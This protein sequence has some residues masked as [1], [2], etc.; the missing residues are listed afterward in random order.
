MNN[1][2]K[3]NSI[4]FQSKIAR[5]HFSN[6]CKTIVELVSSKRILTQLLSISILFS[7]RFH[8]LRLISDCLCIVCSVSCC[9]VYLL[10]LA[11]IRTHIIHVMVGSVSCLKSHVLIFSH[12]SVLYGTERNALKDCGSGLTFSRV[13]G[14]TR[15]YLCLSIYYVHCI[16]PLLFFLSLLVLCGEWC[17]VPLSLLPERLFWFVCWFDCFGAVVIC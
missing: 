16:L 2:S 15:S 3:V 8:P 11:W 12:T 5:A 1:Y 13:N 10:H 14:S 6:A 17:T 7:L 9:L 4:E